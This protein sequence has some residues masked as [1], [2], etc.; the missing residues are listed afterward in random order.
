MPVEELDEW[1]KPREFR[2]RQ[3]AV[4]KELGSALQGES[5]AVI[6][7]A[8]AAVLA[9]ASGVE[10][11]HEGEA[12]P[13]KLS[14]GLFA[15]PD[16]KGRRLVFGVAGLLSQFSCRTELFKIGGV[17]TQLALPIMLQTFRFCYSLT[18]HGWFTK[19]PRSRGT[20][21]HDV[22]GSRSGW[23][24]ALLCDERARGPSDTR[25]RV[26]AGAAK[27]YGGPSEGAPVAAAVPS[28][29]EIEVYSAWGVRKSERDAALDAAGLRKVV[30]E[31]GG[32]QVE[33]RRVVPPEVSAAGGPWQQGP[34]GTG[35]QTRRL[36]VPSRAHAGW[37]VGHAPL[38][39]L[40]TAALC[41][42]L[43]IPL[44]E[45]FTFKE[46]AAVVQG[47]GA[48]GRKSRKGASA[49]SLR[50]GLWEEHEKQGL[51]VFVGAPGGA[52]RLGLG[53]PVLN[54]PPLALADPAATQHQLFVE[55]LLFKCEAVLLLSP[56][57][58]SSTVLRTGSLPITTLL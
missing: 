29:G 41:S 33:F 23:R 48:K 5:P 58:V 22:R 1:F 10:V 55:R 7:A 37:D 18:A 42:D 53:H 25:G 16:A 27:L 28:G 21:V 36:S 26:G 38:D 56:T 40:A 39:G 35:V 12:R 44:W 45:L 2:D 54:T 50:A 14:E 32:T 43:W 49:W 31:P 6:D 52:S 47:D 3:G 30:T 15:Q 46:D 13:G 9:D 51:A 4:A 11:V 57:A 20:A 19:S 34:A 17:A 24:R 8:Q